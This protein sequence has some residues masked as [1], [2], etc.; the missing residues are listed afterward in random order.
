MPR[1]NTQN[2]DFDR[3]RDDAAAAHGTSLGAAAMPPERDPDSPTSTHVHEEGIDLD[4]PADRV[5]YESA[6]DAPRAD[7]RERYAGM[8][9][10]LTRPPPH[11]ASR[12]RFR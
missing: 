2:T 11:P 10:T 9:P 6:Y 4:R 12:N 8:A 5:G 7:V 1:R 3:D